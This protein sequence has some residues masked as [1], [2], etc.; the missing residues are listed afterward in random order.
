MAEIGALC[1][2]LVIGWVTYRTLRRSE[3]KVALND[4]A[5]V[6]GV[7]GG[8][9][10]TTLFDDPD[11]FGFYAVGLAIGFFAYLTVGLIREGEQ[12]AVWM[13]PPRSKNGDD[14]NRPPTR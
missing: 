3:D 4:I 9:A 11:L 12:V 8:G 2:G 1:F 5:T 10:V 14:S 7:V 6:L 13:G